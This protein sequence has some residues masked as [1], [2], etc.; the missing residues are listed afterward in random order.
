MALTTDDHYGL[1]YEMNSTG[2][3]FSVFE[4][5]PVT[6]YYDSALYV[7]GVVGAASTDSVTDDVYAYLTAGN[8]EGGNP[9]SGPFTFS[10]R[11]F[12]AP[13]TILVV[14]TNAH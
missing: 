6:H 12:G 10:T 1:L 8:V 2:L 7:T 11:N 3:Y 5:N 13:G 4:T 14:A 9:Y